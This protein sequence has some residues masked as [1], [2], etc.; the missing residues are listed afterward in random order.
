MSQS[1]IRKLL[2]YSPKDPYILSEGDDADDVVN[3]Y[4]DLVTM[5]K[6]APDFEDLVDGIATFLDSVSD[7]DQDGQIEKK[8]TDVIRERIVSD[9]FKDQVKS[10]L[11]VVGESRMFTG[12][13]QLNESLEDIEAQMT[14]LNQDIRMAR[15]FQE[16]ASE[17]SEFLGKLRSMNAELGASIESDVVTGMADYMDGMKKTIASKAKKLGVE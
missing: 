1:H 17:V 14:K 8:M 13:R 16:V 15:D 12:K 3:A 4:R 7:I 10:I 6:T 11:S 5:A 2:G 9:D